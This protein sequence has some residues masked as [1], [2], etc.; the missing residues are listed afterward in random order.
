M[1]SQIALLG[2]ALIIGF[3]NGQTTI[4]PKLF[5]CPLIGYDIDGG[6]LDPSSCPPGQPDGQGGQTFGGC[7]CNNLCFKTDSWEECASQCSGVTDR[8]ELIDDGIPDPIYK[9]Y[10]A[11]SYQ[12]RAAQ[13]GSGNSPYIGNCCCKNTLDGMVE[14]NGTIMGLPNCP[15]SGRLV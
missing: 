3:T 13:G 9:G 1:N 7:P 8:V 6:C 5:D 2:A 15:G 14:S 10:V 4:D 12:T 11:W